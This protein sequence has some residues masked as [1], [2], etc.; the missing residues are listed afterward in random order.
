MNTPQHNVD[1]S[2]HDAATIAVLAQAARGAHM[3]PW[4]GRP[5]VIV[6]DGHSLEYLQDP[7][8]TPTRPAG[9]VKLRDADS[10]VRYY[11]RMAAFARATMHVPLIYATIDPPVFVAVFNEHTEL[12]AGTQPGYR[13]W[14]AV[15]EVPKSREWL[16]WT[17]HSGRAM[18]QL[19]FAEFL[20]NNL[21]DIVSPPGADLLEMTLKFEATRSMKFRSE[22]RLQDGSVNFVFVDEDNGRDAGQVAVPREIQLYIPVFE[23]EA[24]RHMI[25]ARLKYRI[26]DGKLA[27]WYE[28]VRPH[29][30]IEH[31]F[32]RVWET[33]EHATGNRPLLGTP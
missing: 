19:A 13:D 23:N 6:P 14:R 20:E 31:A 27:L 11:E 25:S 26:D 5:F 18:S 17:A 29:E 3:H 24:N 33:I 28:L 32:R 8:P 7:E 30:F 4:N 12:N 9:T 10:F 2:D 16:I 15:F 22:R 21:P 1:Q